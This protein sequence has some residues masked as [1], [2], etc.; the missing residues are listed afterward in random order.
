MACVLQMFRRGLFQMP[1]GN[2]IWT[3]WSELMLS[4]Q[5]VLFCE[6]V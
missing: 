6:V 2:L 4:R 5:C 1:F 3:F